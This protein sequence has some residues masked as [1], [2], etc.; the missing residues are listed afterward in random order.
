MDINA[1]LNEQRRLAAEILQLAD[2]DDQRKAEVVMASLAERLAELQRA[3]D[4]WLT[5]GGFMPTAW[6]QSESND[7]R[8]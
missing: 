5:R 4:E 6:R 1:N 7:V 2:S 8:S 3:M